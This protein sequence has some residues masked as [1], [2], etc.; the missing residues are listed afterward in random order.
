ME[1]KAHGATENLRQMLERKNQGKETRQS[2]RDGW[3]A[4]LAMALASTSVG[5]E[6]GN[7]IK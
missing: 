4:S 6:I 7:L 1:S 2:A 3:G 5:E